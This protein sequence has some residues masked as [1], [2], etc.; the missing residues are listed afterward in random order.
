[1]RIAC[2]TT[3]FSQLPIKDALARISKLG[4]RYVDLLAMHNWAHIFPGDLVQNFSEIANEISIMMKEMDLQVIA[5]NCSMS[6]SMSTG[7]KREI[8]TIVEEAA[9]LIRLAER[10]NVPVVVFQPG[11]SIEGLSFDQAFLSSVRMLKKIIS[12]SKNTGIAV[13]IETHVGSLAEKYNDALRFVAE[14]PGLKLAYDP[15]HFIMS[16]FDLAGSE[17][18]LQHTAH[19]HLRNAVKGNIQ[20]PMKDGDLDFKWVFDAIDKSGYAGA[21]SIEYI[22]NRD[23]E[24]QSDIKLLKKKLETRYYFS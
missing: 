12:G 13:A 14:V 9:A 16:G 1:M 17:E 4:F 6:F 19:V 10:F 3:G 2:S 20:A 8:Q 24:I 18:L 11:G 22:D 21:V 23:R 5:L 15:S 7:D